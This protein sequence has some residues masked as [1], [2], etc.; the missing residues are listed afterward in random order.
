M[1][2]V[3]ESARDIQD[4]LKVEKIKRRRGLGNAFIEFK[5][6]DHKV[7]RQL[8][9]DV[10]ILGSGDESIVIGK[11][12]DIN[13]V[14]SLGIDFRQREGVLPFAELY[15]IHKLASLLYPYYFPELYGARGFGYRDTERK[16]L[17]KNRSITY[18]NV[19]KGQSEGDRIEKECK[20]AGI[21]FDLDPSE[22]NYSTD[23]NGNVMYIDIFDRGLK[24]V[25]DMDVNAVYEIFTKN[26]RSFSPEDARKR[27]RDL[28]RC[29]RRI[30][31]L[32]I[33]NNMFQDINNK[34]HYPDLNEVEGNVIEAVLD[35][36][37]L[38]GNSVDNIMR[39]IKKG[40][41]FEILTGEKYDGGW[42]F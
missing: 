15:Q 9:P 24:A 39:V 7:L 6:N 36:D 1:F 25:K 29:L 22:L 33:V 42:H 12:L 14:V 34:G 2:E 40:V 5:A 3:S 37:I 38:N 20:K 13:R 19:R 10:E 18:G 28:D 32:Q 35:N 8:F 27:K 41:E 30:K 21:H 23:E 11:K 16:R 4:L 26:N 17:D 31:E